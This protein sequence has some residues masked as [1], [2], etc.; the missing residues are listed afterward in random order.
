V[1]SSADAL[2]F[3]NSRQILDSD[4][5][6]IARPGGAPRRFD[7]PVDASLTLRLPVSR[8]YAELGLNLTSPSTAQSHPEDR[9]SDIRWPADR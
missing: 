8:F 1:D 5:A 6:R 7:C 3:W 2:A 4:I 9:A